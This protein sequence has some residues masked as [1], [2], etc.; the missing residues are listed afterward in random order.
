MVRINDVEMCIS[1]EYASHTPKIAVR[2]VQSK[3]RWIIIL[4]H[5]VFSL[6]IF[7]FFGRDS[8][9]CSTSIPSAMVYSLCILYSFN[10]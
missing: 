10:F 9:I 5:V 8:A 4:L 1:S 6:L 7:T 3:T 2:D